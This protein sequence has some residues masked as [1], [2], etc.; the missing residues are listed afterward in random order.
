MWCKKRRRN[1]EGKSQ[2]DNSRPSSNKQPRKESTS[3][4]TKP[5]NVGS[6]NTEQSLKAGNGASGEKI[7]LTTAGGL[8]DSLSKIYVQKKM[9]NNSLSEG[10]PTFEED[11]GNVN[12][13][14]RPASNDLGGTQAVDEQDHV[15]QK[16]TDRVRRQSDSSYID[17]RP[18]NAE[19]DGRMRDKNSD[20]H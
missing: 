16:M 4:G 11:G 5:E 3:G 13:D 8:K 15:L 1:K 6:T 7:S 12:L 9:H 17:Y 18:Y 10:L 20:R 2:E 19:S 14:E